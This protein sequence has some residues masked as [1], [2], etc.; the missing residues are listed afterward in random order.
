MLFFVREEINQGVEVSTSLGFR[1]GVSI[2]ALT[3]M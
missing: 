1:V 3:A 2:R